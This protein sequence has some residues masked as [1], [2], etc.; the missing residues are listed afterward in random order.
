MYFKRMMG[1]LKIVVQQDF[2]P[3]K[4]LWIFNEASLKQDVEIENCTSISVVKPCTDLAYAKSSTC[5]FIFNGVFLPL[6]CSQFS[7]FC[8]KIP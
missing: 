8:L 3:A 5:M 7:I 4:A 6:T 2:T 1:G